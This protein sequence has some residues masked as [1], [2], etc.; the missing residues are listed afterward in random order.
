MSAPGMAVPARRAHGGIVLHRFVPSDLQSV[1]AREFGGNA[2]N[3]D[4]QS[5]GYAL[6]LSGGDLS[7][8]EGPAAPLLWMHDQNSMIGRIT[9][10]CATPTAVPFRAQ[11]LAPG[12][13]PCADKICREL[14]AG[15][16]FGVSLSFMIDAW[17]PIVRG[18]PSEGKRATAW[19]ALELS[20]CSVPVDSKCYVTERSRRRAVAEPGVGK[21]QAALSPLA[22]ALDAHKAFGLNH[23]AITDATQ[24][25]DEH[26][27]RM[28][29]SL[30]ALT[31]AI[32]SGDT[33]AQ[34]QHLGR[35]TRCARALNREM[36][37]ISH[38]HQDAG[39]EL[40]GIGRALQ[41][42]STFLGLDASGA[43]IGD[44]D[45]DDFDTNAG[46]PVDDGDAD[47]QQLGRSTDYRRRQL[48]KRRLA[49]A[50]PRRAEAEA[51]GLV[52]QSYGTP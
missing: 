1:G 17:E 12:A 35:C 18:K 46:Y 20:L 29:T 36:K 19:T 11:F 15:A 44:D 45:A 14:K 48:D 10:I 42:A 39:D 25:L 16:P 41:S 27:S 5:D 23:A 37:K 50:D 24:R 7:R 28:G 38:A 22:A 9:S 32:Q 51:L 52:G 6:D 34:A 13:S 26:R 33:E 31:A 49:A 4:L 30:R 2:A 3:P 8:L 43:P 21:M 40:T 47:D